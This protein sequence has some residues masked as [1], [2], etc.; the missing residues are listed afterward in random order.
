[1]PVLY[2]LSKVELVAAAIARGIA[3]VEVWDRNP[4]NITFAF[5]DSPQLQELLANLAAGVQCVNLAAYIDA[6]QSVRSKVMQNDPR[7]QVRAFRAIASRCL[8]KPQPPEPSPEDFEKMASLRSR[9]ETLS[10]LNKERGK[11]AVRTASRSPRPGLDQVEA[12]AL[13][14]AGVGSES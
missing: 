3:P 6:L 2:P 8:A 14:L 12:S 5:E 13:F 10:R 7:F 11:A 9:Q 1:M 4:N